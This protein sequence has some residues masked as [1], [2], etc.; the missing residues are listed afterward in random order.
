MIDKNNETDTAE[1]DDDEYDPDIPDE[2]DQTD[3]PDKHTPPVSKVIDSKA[4]GNPL[5]VLLLCL[6]AMCST[7]FKRKK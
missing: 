5:L 4:T 2:D 1:D 3:V 6:I 7:Q